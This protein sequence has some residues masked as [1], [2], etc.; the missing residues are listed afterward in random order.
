MPNSPDF[1]NVFSEESGGFQADSTT[2]NDVAAVGAAPEGDPP[3]TAVEHSPSA[4]PPVTA[5]ATDPTAGPITS[6][7]DTPGSLVS[8]QLGDQVQSSSNPAPGAAGSSTPL[9]SPA[10]ATQ[11]QSDASTCPVTRLQ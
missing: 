6:H 2:N 10:A 8:T 11:Q 4:D 1:T 5:Q 9:G 3:A 7:A